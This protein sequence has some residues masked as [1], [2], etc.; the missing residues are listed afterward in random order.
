MTPQLIVSESFHP[1]DCLPYSLRRHHDIARWLVSTILQR[2]AYTPGKAIRPVRLYAPYLKHMMGRRYRDIIAAMLESSVIHRTPYRRGQHSFGYLLDNRFVLDR[3]VR[4]DVRNTKL[5]AR[6]DERRREAHKKARE[7]FLP[8]HK[9]LFRLQRQLTVDTAQAARLLKTIP[10]GSNPFD[11][12]GILLA[13]IADRQF[14]MTIGPSSGR[15]FN[16]ITSMSRMVRPALR[17]DGEPLVGVDVCCCQPALLGMLIRGRLQP[18]QSAKSGKHSKVLRCLSAVLPVLPADCADV[19]AFADLSSRGSLYDFLQMALPGIA[20]PLLKRR[21]LCDVFGKRG[22]Y[23]SEVETAFVREFPNVHRFIREVNREDHA[24]L[25]RTLQRCESL[26]VIEEVCDQLVQ[27][28][29]EEF[30]I[31]IH[32]AVYSHPRHITAVE[33]AFTDAF[34]KLGFHMRLS[35]TR[36][37]SFGERR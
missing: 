28:H 11:A 23:P 31:T 19:R 25:L 10:V 35:R 37:T 33:H 6:I 22:D 9:R 4:V 26:L 27:R 12:Q 30:A 29:P 15:I 8:I 21:L 32:D 20:R 36:C 7:C 14:K 1:R 24:A 2:T 17:I 5:I 3:H 18:A 16:S 13:N 34:D